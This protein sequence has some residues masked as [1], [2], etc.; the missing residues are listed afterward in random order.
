MIYGNT[1]G[2]RDSEL[3][4]LD[5][6][7]D[8]EFDKDIFAPIE[9]LEYLAIF[10]SSIGREISVYIS[11]N[12]DIVDI[13][14]GNQASVGL[15]NI[16][17]RRNQRRL[18][19]IRCIHTHPNGNPELSDV[20]ISSLRS[21][22]FDCIAAIGTINGKLT[23]IQAAFLDPTEKSGIQITEIV[24]VQHL[25]QHKWMDTILEIDKHYSDLS[26]N[27]VEE[28]RERAYLVSLEEETSELEALAQSAGA[29]VVGIMIQ[30]KQQPDAATFIGTGKAEQLSLA[31]QA[32]EADLVIFD[33]ELTGIQIRNLEQILLGVRVLDR[34]N[35]ILDIFAQRAQSK[36][37][38]LQVEIAQ[39]TYQLPRLLGHGV[40]MSRLG[41]GIGT[42]GPGETQLEIDRRKI[43]K[44][45]SDLKK[46]EQDIAKQRSLRREKRRKNEVPVIALVGYTNAGKTT[47]L[48]YLSGADAFAKDMLFATLDPLSRIISMPQ[49]RKV[50]LVDT[51]GFINNLPHALID[52]F[53]STLEEVRIAD[54]ILIISDGSSIDMMKQYQVV[55]NVLAELGASDKPY[56]HIINKIDK[57]VD[58]SAFPEAIPIS[59]ATGQGIDDLYTAIAETLD[60]S[61]IKLKVLIPYSNASLEGRLHRERTIVEEKYTEKGYEVT[62]QADKKLENYLRNILGKENVSPLSEYLQEE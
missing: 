12:G 17:L 47:L 49:G 45:L 6:L 13:S 28:L 37:G 15:K 53:R 52:A 50:M 59:A 26:T 54:I 55:N 30:K 33:S 10:S 44:R 22:Y 34:T 48:N 51:V 25:P 27:K 24:S 7:Y 62:I 43:R 32:A 1:E 19:K 3:K 40:S 16:R 21:M 23:G 46:Q 41:G 18:S 9:L 5:L 35:L 58:V 61:F 8:L 60:N 20:D 29:D 2:I 38:R 56:I 14:I 4:K 36:E 42:R 39:L 11:R 57:G 31:C